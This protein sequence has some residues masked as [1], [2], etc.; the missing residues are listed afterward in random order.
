MT[1]SPPVETPV[2]GALEVPVN[3]QANP[4]LGSWVTVTDD[5]R[6]GLRLGKAELGQG[7]A[8]A[9]A[10]IAADALDLPIERLAVL[11]AHTVDGPDEGLTAGSMST[12]TSGAAWR[13]VGAVVRDLVARASEPGADVVDLIGRLDPETD[14][15]TWTPSAPSAPSTPAGRRLVGTDLPRLDLPD[16][17][18][19]RP[20]FIADVRPAGM[21]VG[22]VVRPP[23]VGAQ[24][25]EVDAAAT[26][27]LDVVRD[28]SFLGVVVDGEAAAD[29]AVAR[30]RAASRW[31]EHDLLPDEDD[32][33][34][35][36]RAGPHVDIPL[37]DEEGAPAGP[38]DATH[39][40]TYTRPFLV[41]ASIAPS[42]GI[43]RWTPD[44]T[45][46]HVWSH[47]QGIHRLR[48]AIAL[49]LDAAG[50]AGQ[51]RARGERRLL[52]PQ[53]RRRCGLRRRAARPR[54]AGSTGAGALEPQRRA[55]LGTAG[56]RDVG[57]PGRR[58]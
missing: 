2:R 14:L 20:R 21:L 1:S 30:V 26:D 44:G 58:P 13:H 5:G 10:Q 19:G 39:A 56:V 48:D 53:R 43:A 6:V 15:T 51:R 23:S 9:L 42:C 35:F 47:S 54:R 46:V 7:I 41:H 24:L 18:L 49:A 22:R 28:G 17:V 36:L 16:K 40:A 32:L 31:E 50:R 57:R 29:A 27:G 11:P 37:V 55:G 33:D 52:R 45:T 12:A 3:V 34:A 8:T 25:V 38:D 4:R